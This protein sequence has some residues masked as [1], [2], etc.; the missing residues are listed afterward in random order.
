M[1][2]ARSSQTLTRGLA[3]KSF[4][5][6]VAALAG[7][8][9]AVVAFAMPAD[10]LERLVAASGLPHLLAAA[11]PPLG[12]KARGAIGAAGAAAAFG[13]VYLLLRFL[14]SAGRGKT[15]REPEFDASGP[16]LRR[17]DIHPDAP[18]CRPISATRDLGEPAPPLRVVPEEP[19]PAPFA[20]STAISADPPFEP[21][22]PPLEDVQEE[23][24]PAW[25][26]DADAEIV[27]PLSEPAPP[28]LED[29]PEEA[30]PPWLAE[31]DADVAE[32]PS[33]PAMDEQRFN[34]FNRHVHQAPPARQPIFAVPDLVEPEAPVPELAAPVP[35]MPKSVEPEAV[36]RIAEPPPPLPEPVETEVAGEP[37]GFVPPE[38]DEPAASAASA[39]VEEPLELTE[40]ATP[41][42]L[43]DAES[44]AEPEPAVE[45]S[46][47]D[48]LRR[49]EQGLARRRDHRVFAAAPR[50]H[51]PAPQVFP[52]AN[53]DRLQNAI[54]SLQRF[55]ARGD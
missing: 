53:D 34:S 21:A 42:W 35:P 18:V 51:A 1:I 25:L 23:P 11:E 50:T 37:A 32:T 39:E 22:P 44:E 20:E 33:E 13:L 10:L 5:L 29:V 4:D 17:R 3:R 12:L 41:D 46:L 14:D 49:L 9:A 24:A 16:R 36:E 31:A 55:A 43:A 15:R 54:D 27:D 8:A 26:A 6:P 52:E 45:S 47:P 7:L 48:L 19:V 38:A 2:A 30:T 40:R 28:L